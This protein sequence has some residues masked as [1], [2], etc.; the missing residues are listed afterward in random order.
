[1]TP[2]KL[3]LWSQQICRQGLVSVWRNLRRSPL[4]DW[5]AYGYYRC[6][7]TS[8]QLDKQQNNTLDLDLNGHFPFLK[9]VNIDIQGHDNII[10]IERNVRLS[11][12]KIQVKGSNHRL[13]ISENCQIYGGCL[14]MENSHG[15]LSIGSDTTIGEALIGVS[16]NHQQ[17]S[18]GK[19]CMFAHG[20]D[21]RCG[22]SHAIVDLE[23][24]KRLNPAQSINI[25]DHVWL[26]PYTRILKG[27]TIGTDSIIG[28][29]A[30]VTRS[31]PENVIALGA[32]AIVKR[33]GITWSRGEHTDI[34]LR[35]PDH[36]HQEI[37]LEEHPVSQVFCNDSNA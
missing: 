5:L 2:P 3:L 11:D 8:W 18:I 23:T 32:P 21:I 1:M 31:V 34:A 26:G 24:G 16:E 37:T 20:I 14:W 13:V 15:E 12:L 19:D 6:R 22:D 4:R 25:Q 33:E 10:I 29:G 9:N 17:V 28:M 7:G 27:V 36:K 30:I 35:K